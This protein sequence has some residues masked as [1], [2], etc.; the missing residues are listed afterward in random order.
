[1]KEG[2]AEYTGVVKRAPRL[3][4]DASHDDSSSVSGDASTDASEDISCGSAN[5]GHPIMEPY[6]KA[7]M[8]TAREGKIDKRTE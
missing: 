1:M 8:F 2:S 5:A 7:F 3:M 4:S 6:A